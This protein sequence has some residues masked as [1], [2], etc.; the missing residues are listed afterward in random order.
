[1]LPEKQ[2]AAA[3]LD[4]YSLSPKKIFQNYNS[5]P[6][7]RATDLLVCVNVIKDMGFIELCFICFHEKWS[8]IGGSRRKPMI[9]AMTNL[10]NSSLK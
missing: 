5:I 6:N 10:A 7:P 9:F 8:L 2:L 4:E 3:G 1:M